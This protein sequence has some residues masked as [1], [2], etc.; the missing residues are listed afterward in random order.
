LYT[1]LWAAGLSGTPCT[2]FMVDSLDST[3]VRGS[4]QSLL[5]T[6][7]EVKNAQWAPLIPVDE[8]LK[9]RASGL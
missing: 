4:G 3:R 8:K 2:R 6:L 7:E 9:C 5:S 1:R